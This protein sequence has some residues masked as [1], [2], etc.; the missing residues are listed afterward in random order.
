MKF[1]SK[2]FSQLVAYLAKNAKELNGEYYRTRKELYQILSTACCVDPETVR[3][4]TR[5]S[6]AP[7]PT[8]LVRLE[9]L[10]QVKPGFFEIGDDEVLSTVKNY[11]NK[12]KFT[13]STNVSDFTKG[14]IFHL[15]S[16]MRKYF[17][18]MD[19]SEERFEQLSWEIEGLRIALPNNVYNATK[20]FLQEEDFE[21]FIAAQGGDEVAFYECLKKLFALANKWEELATDLLMPYMI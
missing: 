11:T 16:L 1:N 18:N 5:P 10:L 13:M 9:N 2:L 7:N 14:K 21:E 6:R 3:S 17:E 4:W 20:R 15:H 8:S 19:D 12:E